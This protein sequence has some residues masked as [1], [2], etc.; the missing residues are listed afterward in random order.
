MVKIKITALFLALGVSL[1]AQSFLG[2]WE[3]VSVSVGD[4]SMTPQARWVIFTNQGF[5]SGNGLLRNGAGTFNYDAFSHMLRMNDTLGLDDQFGAFDV[6]QNGDTM[7]WQRIEEGEQVSV[8]LVRT[9][10]LPLRPLDQ[11]VGLW[12][13]EEGDQVDLMFLSWTKNYR[14][15]FKDG[16]REQGVW[17]GHPHRAEII[18]LPWDRNKE[19]RSFKIE[20]GL[21]EELHFQSTNDT[22]EQ[23]HFNRRRS[24]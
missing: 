17:Y 20:T 22:A 24:F 9:Q 16:S 7:L 21:W 3:V 18:F 4:R 19:S 10:D 13:A 2:S 23:H 5:E 15:T 1:S 6:E 8:R 11:C 14:I 12:A